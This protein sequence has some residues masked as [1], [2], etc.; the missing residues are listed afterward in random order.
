MKPKLS[1]FRNKITLY[2]RIL[3]YLV[4]MD[5]NDED[6]FYSDDEISDSELYQVMSECDCSETKIVLKHLT[7]GFKTHLR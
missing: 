6:I 7:T 2:F 1:L 5:N 4:M 3:R